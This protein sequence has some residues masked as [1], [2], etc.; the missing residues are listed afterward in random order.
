[1]NFSVITIC[2]NNESL[3]E[4][5]INSLSNQVHCTYEHIVIDGGSTDSTLKNLNRHKDKISI[6]LS[7]PDDGIYDA[8]NKGFSLANGD[9]IGIHHTDDTYYDSHVLYNVA[10]AFEKTNAD[11]VYGDIEMILSNGKVRRHWESKVFKNGIIKSGQIPH[12]ALFLSNKLVKKLNPVFDST[13]KIAADLK[14]Q[15]IIANVLRANGY[16]LKTLVR[17]RIGGTSTKNF[18]SYFLG[19]LESRRAWNEIYGSGGTFFV[20]KKIISKIF[21][22]RFLILGINLIGGSGFIGTR[23]CESFS[24]SGVP[25]K[26][27]DKNPSQAF[28]FKSQIVDVR[29]LDQLLN[30]TSE[31]STIINL[32]AEHKDNVY[33]LSLYEQVN[34]EGARN[35]CMVASKK[36]SIKSFSLVLLQ[37]MVLHRLVLMNLEKLNLLMNMVA[38]NIRLSRYSLTG[39]VKVLKKEH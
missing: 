13:Y 9:I 24:T 31:K 34:V 2:Y 29:S 27:L 18:N 4:S 11:Y 39:R 32:A 1:M 10:K 3:I 21:D 7:E 16:Y 15:L 6:L 19:W 8:L 26:I 5:V 25:F 14:Q 20:L 30:H 22:I 36:I 38:Q 17:M 37:F 35:I 28:P 12:P 23:L 33:P